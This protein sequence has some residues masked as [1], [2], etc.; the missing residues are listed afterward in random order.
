MRRRKASVVLN[1]HGGQNLAKLPDMLAVLSAAGWKTRLG[2]KLYGGHTQELAMKAAEHG[3]DLL[4]AYGGDGTLNQVVNG[5]MSVDYQ[6]LVG[7]IPGGT[8]NVWATEVGIPSDAIKAALTLVNSVARPVDVGHIQV[9]ELTVPTLTSTSPA[10]SDTDTRGKKRK[11]RMGKA[12]TKARQHFLLMAGLGIDAAVMGAVSKPLKYRLGPVAVGLAAARELPKQQPFSLE[13]RSVAGSSDE[14]LWSGKALQ[15]VIGNSRLYA[16][17]VEMTPNAAIDDGLLDVCVITSGDPLTTLQ[18]IASLLLRHSPDQ[19]TAE[20]FQGAH[21]TLRVPASIPLQVDGSAVKLKDYLCPTDRQALQE[22]ENQ[23][24]VMVTYQ[25]DALSRALRIAIPQ[26][27]NPTLF[28]EAH[29]TKAPDDQAS[30]QEKG[31]HAQK[32][33]TQPE[34]AATAQPAFQEARLPPE[35]VRA[36]MGQGQKMK[37]SG[38]SPHPEKKKTFILAGTSIS[39]KTGKVKP[40]GIVVDEETVVVRSSGEKVNPAYVQTLKEGQEVVVGGKKKNKWGVM[41]ATYLLM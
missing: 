14:V 28:Q 15:V 37:V 8:A 34:E 5:A 13:L 3:A 30:E 9:R 1:P 17:V 31:A 41:K 18:Q 6:G 29:E 40:V 22:A 25:F 19:V 10:A 11:K 20:Y 32:Q 21:L 33:T 7:V 4:I 39:Q 38:A 24:E 16:G 26:D 2:M 27:Y 23:A 36:L 12:R 35:L